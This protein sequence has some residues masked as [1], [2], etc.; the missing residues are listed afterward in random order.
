MLLFVSMGKRNVTNAPHKNNNFYKNWWHHV[1]IST[2]CE[3]HNA[4]KLIDDDDDDDDIQHSPKHTNKTVQSTHWVS[5]V[6][7]WQCVLFVCGCVL[8]FL[9]CV[10]V[11]VSV[12]V[13]VCVQRCR[14]KRLHE[15]IRF[16][17]THNAD[18]T[19]NVCSVS[20]SLQLAR[21]RVNINMNR[22]IPKRNIVCPLL[23][24]VKK[25]P[26]FNKSCSSNTFGNTVRLTAAAADTTTKKRTSRDECFCAAFSCFGRAGSFIV[27]GVAHV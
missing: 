18:N 16:A 24:S 13:C 9:L 20:A 17:K 14:R 11:W 6:W 1:K 8:L 7:V 25:N 3:M 22:N 27:C 5:F 23:G 26:S 10:C 19:A 21:Y 4:H 15:P 12:L 2:Q